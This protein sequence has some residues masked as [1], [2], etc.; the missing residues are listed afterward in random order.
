[1]AKIKSYRIVIILAIF[2]MLLCL[3]CH[4]Q[5]TW[6]RYI[7]S[8]TIKCSDSDTVVNDETY[9][10]ISSGNSTINGTQNKV[11]IVFPFR[12]EVVVDTLIY[13]SFVS[14]KTFNLVF[15]CTDATGAFVTQNRKVVLRKS[16]GKR[17][18][19]LVTVP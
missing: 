15:K 11:F 13:N 4:A 2:M 7:H 1:M 6:G 12:G 18:Q 14:Q 5:I 3:N 17:I 9:I 19:S 10:T 16:G 8:F